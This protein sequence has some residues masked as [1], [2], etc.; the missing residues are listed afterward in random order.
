M[1]PEISSEEYG[2]HKSL[3]KYHRRARNVFGV[4]EVKLNLKPFSSTLYFILLVVIVSKDVL[5]FWILV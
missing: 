1:V 3:E 2:T 4:E 5:D